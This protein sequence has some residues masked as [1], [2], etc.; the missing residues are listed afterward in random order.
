MTRTPPVAFG[1]SPLCEGA[2]LP[3]R[4]RSS[5]VESVL[6]RPNR[7][8]RRC[9]DFAV[10]GGVRV[11]SHCRSNLLRVILAPA[12]LTRPSFASAKLAARRYHPAKLFSLNSGGRSPEEFSCP[13]RSRAPTPCPL[14]CTYLGENRQRSA[15]GGGEDYSIYLI[16]KGD[17][18]PL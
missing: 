14:P 1:D 17:C 2:G 15:M 9:H 4:G 10:A 13:A 11:K 7:Q 5:P 12:R 3:L 18:I 8:V 6:R 16:S